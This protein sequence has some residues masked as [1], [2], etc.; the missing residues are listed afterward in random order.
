[1]G[2]WINAQQ[3]NYL[4][5]QKIMKNL[6]IQKLWEEFIEKYNEYLFLQKI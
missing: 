6:D 3:N 1:M 4:K 2:N 5:K